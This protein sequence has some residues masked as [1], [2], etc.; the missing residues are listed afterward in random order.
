[1]QATGMK[2]I[3]CL[4][5]VSL[6]LAPSLALTQ[7]C[8][9]VWTNIPTGCEGRTLLQSSNRMIIKTNN[10][11]KI[12]SA[13][14]K[15]EFQSTAIYMELGQF[16]F[17]KHP[18]LLKQGEQPRPS[19]RGS[20]WDLREAGQEREFPRAWFYPCCEFELCCFCNVIAR[21]LKHHV[22]KKQVGR[23]EIHKAKI[24]QSSLLWEM[25]EI[26][27]S[28]FRGRRGQA[29]QNKTGTKAKEFNKYQRVKGHLPIWLAIL[30]KSQS[31]QRVELPSSRADVIKL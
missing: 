21:A 16:H 7:G 27:A 17:G 3:S 19:K 29:R 18:N 10:K 26:Q 8:S 5:S 2:L 12:S 13:F 15:Y 24:R 14:S 28:W 22:P 1:M 23:R 9:W 31:G 6:I 30:Q 11:I 20:G 4:Q 25:R